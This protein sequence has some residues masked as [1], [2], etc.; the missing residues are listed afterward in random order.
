MPPIVPNWL[1]DW[2]RAVAAAGG[3]QVDWSCF[4][5]LVKK[6]SNNARRLAFFCPFSS[7]PPPHQI[8]SDY[9]FPVYLFHYKSV[10][11]KGPRK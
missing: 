10:R 6:K 8:Q 1:A 9:F 2:L 7:L 5:Y 4:E 11:E 3:G